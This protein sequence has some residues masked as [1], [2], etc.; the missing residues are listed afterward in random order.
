[1]A[2][3]SSFSPSNIFTTCAEKCKT[4][5]GG[6]STIKDIQIYSI[7]IALEFYQLINKY[8]NELV[9]NLYDYYYYSNI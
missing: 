7:P 8:I 4:L 5:Y 9:T 2:V 1:M 3:N 6:P